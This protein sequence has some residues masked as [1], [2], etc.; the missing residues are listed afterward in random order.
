MQ[1]FINPKTINTSFSVPNI[2]VD[3]YINLVNKDSISVL[4]YILRNSNNESITIEK[5]SKQLVLTKKDIIDII[6]YWINEN[7]IPSDF[8]TTKSNSITTDIPNNP[9]TCNNKVEIISSKLSPKVNNTYSETELLSYLE[10]IQDMMS[11]PI[12]PMEKRI[13]TDIITIYTLPIDVIFMAIEYCIKHG[14]A[15]IRYIKRVCQT[16]MDDD[17]NTHEKAEYHIKS[18]TVTNLN[19]SKIK[20]LFG[21]DNRNLSEKEKSLVSNWFNTLNL[22]IDLIT[23]AYNRTIDTIGKLSFPYINSILESWNKNNIKSASQID[24]ISKNKKPND[25]FIIKNSINYTQA[26]S[27]NKLFD[28]RFDNVP[29]I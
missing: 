14:K 26:S 9:I 6:N 27:F 1:Y 21:I 28:E 13:F 5:I 2:I 17:I 25:K 10:C 12:T 23:L 16:W 4:M 3:K 7:I 15:N 11:R 19:E 29:E 18:L 20:K 22:D 24:L 8:I